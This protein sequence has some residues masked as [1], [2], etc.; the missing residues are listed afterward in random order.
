L[1]NGVEDKHH[2]GYGG[3]PEDDRARL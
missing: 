1:E 2:E 3:V